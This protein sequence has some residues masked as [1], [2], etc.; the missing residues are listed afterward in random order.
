MVKKKDF[1]PQPE[2]VKPRMTDEKAVDKVKEI[3]G[4]A[5]VEHPTAIEVPVPAPAKNEAAAQPAAP[6]QPVVPVLD[7]DKVADEALAEAKAQDEAAIAAQTRTASQNA[8]A[9]THDKEMNALKESNQARY[10]SA[11]DILADYNQRVEA[12]K[13]QD[14]DA[15]KRSNAYRYIAGLGDTLSSLANLVGTAHGA[16]NQKQVYNGSA[17][18]ERA[19]AARK[20]RKVELDELDKRISEMR[21]RQRE[22]Q[23]AGT[24]AEAQLKAKQEKER[25]AYQQ[26]QDKIAREEKRY[27][28]EVAR[29]AE[30]N[31]T[32]RQF[33]AKENEKNRKHQTAMN[34]ADNATSLARAAASGS[35]SEKVEEFNLGGG[36][37][38]SVPK[39]R[40]NDYNITELYDMVPDSIKET[41]GRP[42]LDSYGEVIGY[43][44]PTQK[45]M[46]QAISRA[47][48]NDSKIKD[49]IRNLGQAGA[50]QKQSSKTQT[51]ASAP[52]QAAA[53]PETPAQKEPATGAYVGAK[54]GIDWSSKRNTA[55]TPS[56]TQSK[57]DVI[58]NKEDEII[59]HKDDSFYINGTR[60]AKL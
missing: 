30:E 26:E 7:P 34:N 13:T 49:A 20:E 25:I 54:T 14:A 53:S 23:A 40:M 60:Y 48:Q 35:G 38:V 28:D 57:V 44:P 46:L 45:E 17:L 24:L 36:E 18:A 29:K 42:K 11:D 12:L 55:G 58:R 37:F 1:I 5:K 52:V 10:S 31:E 19:E 4:E 8:L 6:A 27:L 47:A 56:K 32:E 16:Q 41:A 43:Y 21:Q 15:E 51:K 50:T 9:N 22:M 39:D 33:R 59:R 3:K 2:D